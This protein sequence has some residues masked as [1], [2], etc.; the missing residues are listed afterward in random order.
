MKLQYVNRIRAQKA[1]RLDFGELLYFSLQAVYADEGKE[2]DEYQV[3]DGA[4]KRR[5]VFIS[6]HSFY[7]RIGHTDALVGSECLRSCD[8]VSLDDIYC[9][10]HAEQGQC[11]EG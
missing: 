9:L 7:A 2:N 3:D 8:A 10:K 6:Q 11:K 4:G 1:L 5:A